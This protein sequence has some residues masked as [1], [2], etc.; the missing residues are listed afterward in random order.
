MFLGLLFLGFGFFWGGL[1]G[2]RDSLFV[3]AFALEGDDDHASIRT[4]R[5]L[6]GSF[7]FLLRPCVVIWKKRSHETL[8]LRRPT[9]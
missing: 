6:V 8:R 9:T 7:G 4:A 5:P 3:G 1:H 2:D